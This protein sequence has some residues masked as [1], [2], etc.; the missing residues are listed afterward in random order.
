MQH[1]L[2]DAINDRMLKKI[3]SWKS[4]LPL[5]QRR[6]AFPQTS[7]QLCL[8]GMLGGL[9]AALLIILFRLS[10][11]ALQLL[12]LEQSDD[13][14]SVR[15]E[16]RW[17][18]PLGGAM[19]IALLAWITGYRHYRLGIPFVIHRIKLKYGIMPFRNTL[20]QFFGGVLALTSGF[21]VGREGPSVHLG[22][23]GASTVGRYL[24]LP[25]NSI[26]ILAGCGIAAGISASFNTPL[27]AVIFVMEVVLREYKVHVFIPVMLASVAGAV[28]TQ[29]VFGTD[30]ELALL[31]IT[32]LSGWH[33]PYLVLCGI[34]FGAVSFIFNSN[35]MRTI[36]LFR[37]WPL[38]L[39]LLLAGAIT[40]AIGYI[41]PHAMGAES[42]AIHYAVNMPDA[43]L[44]LLAIFAGK[45]LLTIAALGLGVPGGVIGPIFGIGIVLGTLLSVIPTWLGGDHAIAG[46]YAV[47]GMAGLMA[48][49]LH[50]PLAALVAVMELSYNPHIIMPAM[51]VIVTAYVTGV[52]FFNNKSLFLLQLDFMQMPYKL[53]PA[54]DVL[55]KVGVLALLDTQYQILHDPTEQE[56]GKTL[57]TLHA[58]QQLLIR[59]AD[60][61]E[62]D[63]EYLLVSYDLDMAMAG[64][65]SLRYSPLQGLSHQATMAEVFALLADQRE[66]AVYIYQHNAPQQPIGI[67]R[68]DQ[69]N[70]LLVKQNNL[71]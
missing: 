13:F 70:S 68:W 17:L 15:A 49:S 26:R 32:S 28:L 48:A 55:Q 57:D 46:T 38:F 47:L 5:L 23:Y 61:A 33:L 12:F 67:I 53:A 54:D 1:A 56:I 10:I 60:T 27:A 50:A 7:L 71:L 51:L 9:I 64:S 59:R 41:I 25:C 69:V 29:S 6:L 31:E 43:P 36:R 19:L 20:N 22:A 65:G 24:Q 63:A 34:V 3:L 11:I 37:N 66:G 18:L 35:M 42:G 62:S 45:M 21:S 16:I 58:A 4:Q 39:R 2:Y 14:S 30:R 44:V 40:A 8:L 52:Q